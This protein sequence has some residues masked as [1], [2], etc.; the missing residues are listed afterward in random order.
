MRTLGVFLVA[1]AS[2]LVACGGDD[3]AVR[4]D[5]TTTSSSSSSSTTTTTATNATCTLP[6]ADVNPK[7]G[8][9]ASNLALLTDVRYGRQPCADRVVFDFREGAPGY[10]FEYR[11]GPFTFGESGEP[12]TIAGSAFVLVRFSP[13]SGVDLSQPD[14]PA[15]Y[16]GPATITPQGLVYVREIRRLSDFEGELVWVIGVD[17]M[18]P[19]VTASLTNPPRIYVDIG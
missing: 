3:S 6:G 17:G 15:T 13:A 2:T 8:A 1:C 14:I 11:P 9:A 16:T 19:F 5:D 7:S 12:V 4:T 18:R 10:S